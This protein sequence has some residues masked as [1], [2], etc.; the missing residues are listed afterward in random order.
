LLGRVEAFIRADLEATDELLLRELESCQPFVAD[1]LAHVTR[2]RGKR[3][4]PMLV[5]LAAAATG[6]I[7]HEHHV[8]AAVIE[9]VHTATLVHDDVLDDAETRRHIATVNVRW[10][11][12]TSV[13]FGDYLFTHA[14]HLAASLDGTHACRVIG[15]ATNVVCEGELAQVHQSGNLDLNESDYLG[16]IA[17]KTG[18]LCAVSCHLGAHF[19]GAS[20]ST[21]RSLE[22]YGRALGVAFQIIDDVLDVVGN[23]HETGKPVHADLK[24]RKL[25]LPLIRLIDQLPEQNSSELRQLLADPDADTIGK[26]T[27]FFEA[28]DA[29]GYSY[30]RANEF[31]A[32]ARHHLN[33]LPDSEA[34][35]ILVELTEFTTQRSY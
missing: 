31:A 1:V 8:L 35:Q 29:I 3:L 16:I 5:L 11:N 30:E 7:R 14:F 20:E 32:T 28:S 23:E 17:A 9:M 33:D 21:V 10:S 15:H 4:R 24:Q 22:A 34:R 25:T 2:F 19:A 26:L 12:E 27:L 18:Q 13:L 6:E